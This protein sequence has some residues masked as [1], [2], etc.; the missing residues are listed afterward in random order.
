MKRNTNRSKNIQVGSG[1]TQVGAIW[2]IRK[3]KGFPCA[4]KGKKEEQ[5][6]A[7]RYNQDE[8]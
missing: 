1:F 5:A 2:Y 6:N 7:T 8:N 4:V 3:I